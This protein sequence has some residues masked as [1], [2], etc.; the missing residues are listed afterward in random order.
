MKIEKINIENFRGFKSLKLAVEPDLNVFIGANG[1]GKTSLLKAVLKSIV[2]YIKSHISPKDFSSDLELNEEDINYQKT[3]LQITIELNDYLRESVLITN[4]FPLG[5]GELDV[6]FA[7]SIQGGMKF[8]DDLIKQSLVYI[9]IIKFFPATG[10]NPKFVEIG[11]VIYKRSQVETWGNIV[12]NNRSYSR[13]LNWFFDYENK[14]LRLKRDHNDFSYEEPN[15]KYVRDA[16]KKLLKFLYNK[17]YTVGTSQR[18]RMGNN[19]LIPTITLRPNGKD[20]IAED[21]AFKSDGEKSVITMVA[22][23]AYNISIANHPDNQE[24]QSAGIVLIDEIEAHL[25]PTWQRKI[26][27]ILRHIFPNIQFFITTHSPQVISSVNSDKVFLVDNFQI[28]K[29]NFQSNGVDSNTLLKYVFNST[30]RPKVYVDLIKKFDKLIEEQ[31]DIEELEA[32]IKEVEQLEQKD[33]GQPINM[34]VEELTLQLAAYKFEL[35]NEMD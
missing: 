28:E 35:E 13:F 12:Q 32:V 30:E 25:H 11:N 34:L 22:D 19:D 1:A 26:I 31:K 23:I 17:D 3:R 8:F 6:V 5:K 21:L 27:P 20:S 9:P 24:K 29:I 16:I 10:Q 4:S 33:Q 14:E 2:F 15:L 18:Q 7:N